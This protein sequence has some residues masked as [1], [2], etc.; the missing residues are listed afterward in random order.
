VRSDPRLD[1]VAEKPKKK[2]LH[3]L[4]KEAIDGTPEVESRA[5]R[6]PANRTWTHDRCDKNEKRMRRPLKYRLFSR[7]S[8]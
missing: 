4:T 5:I 7:G 8:N 3:S 2:G 6:L 1:R